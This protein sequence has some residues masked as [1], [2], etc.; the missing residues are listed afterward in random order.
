MS[1]SRKAKNLDKTIGPRLTITR[2]QNLKLSQFS[3]VKIEPIEGQF[4][5]VV[6]YKFRQLHEVSKLLKS[7]QI[8]KAAKIIASYGNVQ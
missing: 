6:S 3:N 5:S 4:S 2:P 8:F 1:R 7:C